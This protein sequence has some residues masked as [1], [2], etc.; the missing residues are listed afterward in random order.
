MLGL[1]FSCKL[2]WGFYV[3]S[4]GKT[5]SYKNRVLIRPMNFLFPEI[6]LYLYK[7]T[8]R[9][10]MEC[11]CHVSGGAACWYLRLLDTLQK[12]I[13]RTFGCSFAASLEPLAHCRNFPRSLSCRYYFGRCSS[14]LGQLVP[15]PF[16]W[17]KSAR[18]SD[19][20][21]NFSVIIRGYYKDVMS[22][23]S[24]LAP[25]DLGIICL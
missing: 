7:S 20:L 13:C 18:Y 4:I 19:R 16:S 11:C 3:N 17:G 24:F 21:H 9:P 23:I 8:I 6:A 10:C 2:D 14:K 25:L 1:T 22:T 5:A 12:P 15:F